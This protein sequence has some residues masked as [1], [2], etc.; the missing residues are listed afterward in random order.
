ML[1]RKETD[2]SVTNITN[3]KKVPQQD[4]NFASTQQTNKC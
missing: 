3:T 1:S 2:N 4:A